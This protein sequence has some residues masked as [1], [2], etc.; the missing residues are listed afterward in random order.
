MLHASPSK[1]SEDKSLK[2]LRQFRHILPSCQNHEGYVTLTDQSH[3]VLLKIIVNHHVIVPNGKDV[4]EC[5]ITKLPTGLI[6]LELSIQIGQAILKP[7][8]YNRGGL[9]Q[10]LI[11]SLLKLVRN[12]NNC[13]T[14]I[15]EI[16]PVSES[17]HPHTLGVSHGTQLLSKSLSTLPN[18]TLE[19]ITWNFRYA[20]N[21]RTIGVP[22]EFLSLINDN[23]PDTLKLTMKEGLTHMMGELLVELPLVFSRRWQAELEDSVPLQHAVADIIT[24]FSARSVSCVSKDLKDGLSNLSL[25]PGETP[26]DKL[27]ENLLAQQ[28]AIMNPNRTLFE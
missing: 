8:E 9:F 17:E 6:K 21:Q 11:C 4:E 22:P 15:E 10:R 27:A 12:S 7:E 3:V 28:I 5:N 13:L 16:I 20:T 2:V 23:C 19:K 18:A 25:R 1:I 14:E 26:N 24:R